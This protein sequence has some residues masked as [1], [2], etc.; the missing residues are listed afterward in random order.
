MR[1]LLFAATA[2]SAALLS[3]LAPAAPAGS[4]A[5]SLSLPAPKVGHPRPLVVVLADNAGAETSDYVIPYGV[6]KDSGAA[7]VLGVA[8]RP[9]PV[10]LAPSMTVAADETT[11]QFESEHPEGA[12]LIVVPYILDARNPTV[13]AFLK[14]QY[15]KGATVMSICAGALSV[16]E[17]GLFDGR[18]A[19]S[20]WSRLAGLAHHYGQV[21]WVR[22]RRYVQD[23][24]VISTA[25]VTA[26]IPASL[27]LVEAM[28]GRPAAEA[29]AARLGV[30]DWSAQHRTDDFAVRTADIAQGLAN[31]LA[32]WGHERVETPAR[33]GFD[34]IA[35]ALRADAW[36][37]SLRT[38]VVITGGSAPVRS[39]HGLVLTPDAAPRPGAYVIPEHA[40]GG[41]TQLDLALKD[42]DRRYGAGATRLATLELEYPRR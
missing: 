24:R 13:I 19:T 39:R 26:S 28:A 32:F 15:G 42:M 2:L 34:E 7:E 36:G 29:E 18:Q 14:S 23:G 12:D 37:N 40:G 16:A 30:A 10:K 8:T 25:G 41:A 31:L 35:L 11:A 22:D 20:H 27:A 9:G 33:D 1:P 17:A 21:R 5:S 4:P 38:K 3:G 6:L